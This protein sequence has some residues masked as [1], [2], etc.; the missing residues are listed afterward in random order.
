MNDNICEQIKLGEDSIKSDAVDR[1][2]PKFSEEEVYSLDKAKLEYQIE[3][4]K[5]IAHNRAMRKDFADKVY[6]FLVVWCVALYSILIFQGCHEDFHLSDVVLATLCGGTTV[7]SI[8][9]VGCIVRG[10]FGGKDKTI[11]KNRKSRV[12]YS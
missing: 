12:N 3:K 9:L 5:D 11:I 8:G 1:E 6:N 4:N 10:L 7:S 2:L